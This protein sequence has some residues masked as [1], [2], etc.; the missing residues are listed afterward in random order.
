[1]M[2]VIAYHIKYSWGVKYTHSAF[3]SLNVS[4]IFKTR[5][6]V[7]HLKYIY[8]YKVGFYADKTISNTSRREILC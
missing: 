4:E 1:M 5:I 3:T 8:I 2:R 6:V 7:K